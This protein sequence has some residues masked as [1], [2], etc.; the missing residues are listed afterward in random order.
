VK[1]SGIVEAQVKLNA[2]TVR[3]VRGKAL[4]LP[5]DLKGLPKGTFKVTRP[6]TDRGGRQTG[7]H[8]PLPHMCPEAALSGSQPA[9]SKPATVSPHDSRSRSGNQRRAR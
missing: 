9:S 1:A 7:G 5:I 2:Q 8:T 4:S 6:V 3:K